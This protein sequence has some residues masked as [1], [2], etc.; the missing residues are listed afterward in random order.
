LNPLDAVSRFLNGEIHA[1]EMSL[2]LWLIW[3]DGFRAGSEKAQAEVERANAAADY[4]YTQARYSPAELEEMRINAMDD[5]WR[6]YWDA[7]M[8]TAVTG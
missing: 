1:H 5:G 8:P 4:W 7:G 6:A 3:S 2:D